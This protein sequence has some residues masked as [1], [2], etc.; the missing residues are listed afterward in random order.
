[1]LISIII[2]SWNRKSLIF[3]TL[4]SVVNQTSTDWELIIV[5]DHSTDGSFE[6]LEIFVRSHE[7][8]KLFKRNSSTKGANVCR[9]EGAEYAK[10]NY[11]IFLDS[12]DILDVTC[13][14]N[15]VSVLKK[16]QKADFFVFLT[17]TFINTLGD[18]DLYWNIFNKENDLL[19]F[20]NVDPVWQTTSVLWDN[21]FFKKIDGF[22]ENLKCW[23]DWD[24]HI[25]A[26]LCAEDYYKSE[27]EPDNYYRLNE[28]F[29][30]RKNSS[31]NEYL[32]H[33][34]YV[35]NKIFNEIKNKKGKVK[36][37]NLYFAKLYYQMSKLWMEKANVAESLRLL[38]LIKQ[39]KLLSNIE[40][41][42]WMIYIRQQFYLSSNNKSII[43]RIIDKILS[44]VYKYHFELSN[45]TYLKVSLKEKI[46]KIIRDF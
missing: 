11:L 1:M 4:Q 15:R 6:E 28:N 41:F 19:R 31:S 45:A 18:S 24:I 37:Y 27:N 33:R 32:L 20:L 5:D 17:K 36:K 7:N 25:R 44:I 46:D 23:Q 38:S 14:E 39:K 29:S 8:I 42:I 13:I 2:P 16:N 43:K 10:G 26:I 9:N 30:I 21:S 12:D 3:E 40:Y 34:E 35:T 22:D